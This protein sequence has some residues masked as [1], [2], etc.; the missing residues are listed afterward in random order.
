[1][2]WIFLLYALQTLLGSLAGI[3]ILYKWDRIFLFIVRERLRRQLKIVALTCCFYAAFQPANYGWYKMSQGLSPFLL[4]GGYFYMSLL[5]FGTAVLYDRIVTTQRYRKASHMQQQIT[6]FVS[7]AL[8]PV[9]IELVIGPLIGFTGVYLTNNL[10][11]TFWAGCVAGTILLFFNNYASKQQLLIQQ[12]ELELSRL[13]QLNTQTKLNALQAKINPHFLYNTL[14]AMAG[15]ALEDGAKT[16][17]MAVALSV[18]FRYNLNKE[19]S[20][21]STIAEE[22]EMASY[23]LSIE[24]IRFEERLQYS[25]DIAPGV[26]ELPMPRFMIQPLVENAIKHGFVQMT[27]VGIITVTIREQEEQII[28]EVADNG[29]PFAQQLTPGF[30]LQGLQDKLRL[31]Y[32]GK[33]S[34]EF[35][36]QPK[37]I[38]LIFPSHA[39]TL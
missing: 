27:G 24:K 12:K 26:D 8:L 39:S 28:L 34:I 23:Y 31:F 4:I 38:S 37:R 15:L 32:P 1:M 11:F 9:A 14:N 25:F 13:S 29:Q 35:H 18:L 16:S 36:Q 30:G 22:V 20:S 33:F 7:L 17:K 10:A 5:A 3:Y 6:G 2:Q 19:E 21:F